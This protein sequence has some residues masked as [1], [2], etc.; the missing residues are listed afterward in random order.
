MAVSIACQEGEAMELRVH[1]KMKWEGY[2]NWPPASGV[3]YGGVTS[4]LP[5]KTV[6]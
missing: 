1:P 2:S 5:G 3:A 4:F 6:P